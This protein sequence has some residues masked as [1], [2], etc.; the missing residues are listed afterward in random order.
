MPTTPVPSELPQISL[1]DYTKPALIIPQLQGHSMTAVM[2]ELTRVLYTQEGMPDQLAASLESLNCEL[3]TS[4]SLD[5]GAVIP[6]VSV[7]GWRSPR[8]AL[9][10]AP[11]Q[12][13]WRAGWLPPVDMV[14]LV[15]EPSQNQEECKH[16]RVALTGLGK[17][18]L[19]LDM[20]RG[21][22]NAEE[23]WA[24]LKAIPV[25][26]TRQGSLAI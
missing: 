11:A 25:E 24:A 14:F 21:A 12:L 19:R 13:P 18:R 8:F 22:R 6:H 26:P 1:A 2:Q 16:L 3:L 17:D 15:V 7:W 10:R 4:L 5:F 23:M 20:L 9:G